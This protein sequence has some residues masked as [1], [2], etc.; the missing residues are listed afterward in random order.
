MSPLLWHLDYSDRDTLF[1]STTPWYIISTYTVVSE[2]SVL[3]VI[4]NGPTSIITDVVFGTL[5]YG[6]VYSDVTVGASKRMP[7]A[8]RHRAWVSG[9]SGERSDRQQ[10]MR[11]G[12]AEDTLG[13]QLLICE[14]VFF[15]FVFFATL[16]FLFPPRRDA[17]EADL[18]PVTVRFL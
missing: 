18:N 5:L 13:G 7:V 9:Q 6:L 3:A 17:D 10:R 11:R 8:W 4:M 12:W 2:Y 1:T 15:C 14:S 16:H